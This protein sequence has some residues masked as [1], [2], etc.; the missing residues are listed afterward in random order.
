MWFQSHACDEMRSYVKSNHGIFFLD[1]KKLSDMNFMI[2]FTDN[3]LM[4]LNKAA[5]APF[6]KMILQLVLLLPFVK[7]FHPRSFRPF[8]TVAQ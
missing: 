6:R 4:R 2:K 1:F 7:N 8:H 3:L 5:A